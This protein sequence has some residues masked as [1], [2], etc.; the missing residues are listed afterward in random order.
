MFTAPTWMMGLTVDLRGRTP[1]FLLTV[2]MTICD[3]VAAW[4]QP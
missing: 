3:P 4:A 2:A 1:V